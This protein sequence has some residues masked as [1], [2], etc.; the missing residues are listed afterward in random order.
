MTAVI[1]RSIPGEVSVVSRSPR[2]EFATW[3]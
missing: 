3:S 2:I 1:A